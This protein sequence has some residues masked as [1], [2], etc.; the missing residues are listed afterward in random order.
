VSAADVQR[1]LREHL[2]ADKRVTVVTEPRPK[3]PPP[4]PAGQEKK[5]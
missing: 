5:P 4:T 3:A 1:V 2:S